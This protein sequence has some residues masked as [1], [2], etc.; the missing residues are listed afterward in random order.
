MCAQ[1]VRVRVLVY[2]VTNNSIINCGMASSQYWAKFILVFKVS[3]CWPK[4]CGG[5]GQGWGN[6]NRNRIRL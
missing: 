4:R 5:G 1:N 6:R 3:S 2:E